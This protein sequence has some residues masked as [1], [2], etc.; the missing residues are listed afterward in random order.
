MVINDRNGHG[1][2][3]SLGCVALLV[4]NWQTAGHLVQVVKARP[5]AVEALGRTVLWTATAK[6]RP[7]V[8]RHIGA[9][10]PRRVAYEA[11]H[12]ATGTWRW[13]ARTLRA[14]VAG[15]ADFVRR[16]ALLILKCA[17]GHLGAVGGG[18]HAVG[19]G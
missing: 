15:P 7:K 6:W 1:Q 17:R 18:C 12:G 13:D 4:Q 3:H 8:P 11:A 14:V 2:I 9:L 5:W 16:A 10:A 19:T